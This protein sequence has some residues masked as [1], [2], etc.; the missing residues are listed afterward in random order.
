MIK[1][2]EYRGH[3]RNWE[4]LCAELGIDK[5]LSREEREDTILVKAYEKWGCQMA[6]H[7]HGMFAFALWD[8]EA[9]KLFCLRDQFGTKP[10][11]YYQT[12]DGEL[13]YGTMIRTIMVRY[14]TAVR[15]TATR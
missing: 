1:V 14:S 3:I 15:K 8:E 2:K 5:T 9:K 12:K 13:L 6:N 4:A 7:M 11:Y 10:F